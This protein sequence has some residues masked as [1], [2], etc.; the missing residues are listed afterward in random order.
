MQADREYPVGRGED[1]K[2]KGCLQENRQETEEQRVSS[3]S[4]RSRWSC[5]VHGC[6][7]GA[8]QGKT[9]LREVIRET[10]RPGAHVPWNGRW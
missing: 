4:A 6:P 1:R 3:C 9:E 7:E 2:N 5:A 10:A 8:L